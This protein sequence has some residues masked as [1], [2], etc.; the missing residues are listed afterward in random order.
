M[1]LYHGSLYWPTTIEEIPEYPSL[2]EPKQCDV[3]IIGGGMSGALLSYKLSKESLNV[4][5]V[6][7]GKIGKGS[8][9]ANTG[10]LQYSNDKMLHEF[11]E[12]IGEE[13][14]V[15]FYQLCLAGMKELEQVAAELPV[16][17]Q[18][19]KRKSLYYASEKKDVEKLQKEYEMLKKYNFPVEYLTEEAIQN[20]FGFQKPAALLTDGDAEVNPQLFVLTL[21]KEATKKGHVMVYENTEVEE[22]TY[23]DGKWIFKSQQGSI[24]AKHVIYATG[25]MS[26][27]KF[28]LNALLNL[29]RTYAIVTNPQPEVASNWK[30]NCLIWETKRPY[31][32]M[33]TTQDGRI[34]AGGLDEEKM[35]APTD[36]TILKHYGE[37]LIK[38][39]KTHFPTE[40]LKADYIYGATFGETKDGMP[41]IGKHPKKTGIYYCL[42]FGGNGS[43]YSAFG[44]IILKALIV[45]GNHPE[46]DL[47][48][49]DRN[50]KV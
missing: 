43:V 29:N 49:I 24:K 2:N 4:I 22:D 3:L 8:S 26:V 36:K 44:A 42:G 19:Q 45:D 37:R 15:R 32:Y 9:S 30:G 46:A 7:K 50:N 13:D 10:L 6:E 35:A 1:D 12:S 28:P 34:V 20:Q 16:D 23:E 39:I 5:L 11:A 41:F 27:E 40:A 25:Y 21:I 33:R 14:A 48:R 31:F 38:R 47:V 18:F 17:V